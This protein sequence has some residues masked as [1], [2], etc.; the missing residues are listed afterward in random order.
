MPLFFKGKVLGQRQSKY[1]DR[2]TNIIQFVDEIPNGSITQTD[3]KLPDNVA[4]TQFSKGQE[5]TVPVLVKTYS[6]QIY[7]HLDGDT[8]NAIGPAKR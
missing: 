8:Y 7:Y 1:E 4:P 6:G 2:V 5:V 3:I